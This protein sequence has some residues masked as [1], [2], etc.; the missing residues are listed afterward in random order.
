MMTALDS[1]DAGRSVEVLD[2][3]VTDLGDSDGV[4]RDERDDQTLTG[5]GELAE[6][7]TKSVAGKRSRELAGVMADDATRWVSKYS[8]LASEASEQ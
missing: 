5:V 6:Q 3:Q 8:L 7:A 4:D 2:P 1:Q